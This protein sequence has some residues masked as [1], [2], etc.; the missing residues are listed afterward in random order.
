MKEC[1]KCNGES[2]RLCHR[3]RVDVRIE[4]G[5]DSMTYYVKCEDCEREEMERDPLTMPLEHP[6][7][8]CG[9]RPATVCTSCYDEAAQRTTVEKAAGELLSSCKEAKK[10]VAE[11]APIL[12]EL[13]YTLKYAG[14]LDQWE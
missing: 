14:P 11:L 2:D 1:P 3:Y 12:W 7:Q 10:L 13:Q 5:R 6:C 4:Y 8:L 9:R